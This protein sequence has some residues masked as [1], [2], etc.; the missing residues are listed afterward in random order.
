MNAKCPICGTQHIN[1]RYGVNYKCSKC[2]AT[3]KLVNPVIPVSNDNPRNVPT[4]GLSGLIYLILTGVM[5]YLCI[6]VF[7][8]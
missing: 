7:F 4:G 5:L 2:S 3:F 1:L 6:Q 8:M